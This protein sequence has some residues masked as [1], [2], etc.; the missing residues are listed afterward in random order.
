MEEYFGK[1]SEAVISWNIEVLVDLIKENIPDEEYI[2]ETHT[3]Q[4]SRSEHT[5]TK[6]LNRRDWDPWK[7]HG[8]K[9]VSQMAQERAI[10]ILKKIKMGL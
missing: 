5:L 8:T 3:L 6:C 7:E 1:I 9:D 10:D 2:S 4:Y